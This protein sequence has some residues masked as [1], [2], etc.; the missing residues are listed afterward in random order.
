M[1]TVWDGKNPTVNGLSAK[2]VMGKY[3]DSLTNFNGGIRNLGFAYVAKYLKDVEVILTLD[4]DVIPKGD[5]IQD[6]LDILN[7]K[8][9]VSWIST[10]SEYMRGFPYLIRE[11]AEVVLSHGVW[12]GVADWDAPTQLVMGSKRPVSFYRGPIPFGIYFPMCS[13]N[14]CFKRKALP[15]IF[16][17][18]TVPEMRIARTDDIF[19]GVIA[20]REI[21][22]NGWAAV[23]GYATVVHQRESNV[24]KNLQGEALEIELMET[25]WKGEEKHPYF[26]L[27]H[28]KYDSWLKFIKLCK[29]DK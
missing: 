22:K 23:S 25:F 17:F 18:P 8:V 6:H 3:S 13:M 26:D 15:F 10:A 19:A 21:D 16:H 7:K 1:V 29:I 20:K 2:E 27:Y 11:E 9:P 24:F 28:K 5:T 12:D 14:L 4:D